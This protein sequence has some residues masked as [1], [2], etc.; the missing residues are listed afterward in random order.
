MQRVLT[1]AA[2][3]I[4]AETMVINVQ[5]L[6]MPQNTARMRLL[7]FINIAGFLFLYIINNCI[8]GV[9]MYE[10]KLQANIGYGSLREQSFR[11]HINK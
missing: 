7:P 10:E 4:Y 11:H 1:T 6:S 2:D 3:L 8:C 5:P 9:Y